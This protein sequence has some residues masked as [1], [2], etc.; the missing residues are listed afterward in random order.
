MDVPDQLCLETYHARTDAMHIH[1]GMME[2]EQASDQPNE[3]VFIA[4]AMLVLGFRHYMLSAMLC[5]GGKMLSSKYHPAISQCQ[6]SYLR[7]SRTRYQTSAVYQL[8]SSQT[9]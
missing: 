1:E 6:N 4:E 7:N 8:A 2:E 9:V 3:V 5:Y